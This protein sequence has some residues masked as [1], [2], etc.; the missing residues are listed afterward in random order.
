[1]DP[2]AFRLKNYAE[3]EPISGRPFSSKALRECY[4]QGAERFGWAAPPARAAADA[5]RD[6][7][8]V[9]WG[10]G[11]ATFPGADVRRRKP[12]RCCAGT[13]PASWRSAPTTWGRAP[14]RRWRRSP[15]MG[16]G[17]ISISSN[18]VPARPTCPMPA[19][20]AARPIPRRP[21]RRSTMP[22][23]TRSRGSLILPPTTSARRCSAR[24]M[25]ASIARGG[26]LFRRDDESRSE[27]YGDILDRAGLAPDRRP[28]QRRA[29]DPMDAHAARLRHACAWRGVRR[30]QGR[31]RS[32]PDARHAR[33]RRLRG[34][35]DHQ[36]AHGAQPV[37]WRH[38]LGRLVC[39]C[40]S[41]PSWIRSP[42]GR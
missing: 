20:P 11:T 10:M 27:S 16:S 14:G 23:P 4:R 34:R 31:S 8:L 2:L 21:A 17:S 6:G 36:S 38:D 12:A 26:R 5:R 32:R 25:P 1:M 35:S 15:P 33:G 3:V 42:A 7:L 29:P 24:A 19:S 28:W 40:T 22:A 37:L 39:A 30:G 41:R 9:G 18:S 13:A